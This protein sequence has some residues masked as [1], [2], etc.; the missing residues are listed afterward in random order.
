MECI[1]FRPY[2]RVLLNYAFPPSDV[3][4]PASGTRTATINKTPATTKT[5]PA[6][7]PGPVMPNL[8]AEPKPTAASR[9]TQPTA[10]LSSPQRTVV[11]MAPV[12]FTAPAT[13]IGDSGSTAVKAM[14][15][16]AAEAAFELPELQH[17]ALA[18]APYGLS[19]QHG[20]FP[21]IYTVARPATVA[22]RG[23]LLAS[24]RRSNTDGTTTSSQLMFSLISDTDEIISN[25][26]QKETKL[27][28]FFM[29]A[30]FMEFE[31]RKDPRV[32]FDP[33]MM[34][35]Y[36]SRVR[37]LRQLLPLADNPKPRARA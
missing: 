22:P 28:I 5:A 29:S 37:A 12:A 24:L 1:N 30:G 18:R 33:S 6:R 4:T 27:D 23:S 14:A 36:Y 13:L 25:I 7:A 3:N 31:G 32:G 20:S 15:L 16:V 9:G 8:P 11:E 19:A 2:L 35:R 34:T 10:P 21:R 26:M 17:R